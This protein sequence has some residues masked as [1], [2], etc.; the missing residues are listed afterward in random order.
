VTGGVKCPW[1]PF[2]PAFVVMAWSVLIPTMMISSVA[3]A[4]QMPFEL[5]GTWS[6]NC[7]DP[8]AEQIVLES[9]AVSIVFDGGRHAYAGV[10]VSHTWIGGTKAAGDRVWLLT[11][12][13]AGKPYDFIIYRCSDGNKQAL[14]EQPA[15]PPQAMDSS[16]LATRS[17]HQA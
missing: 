1:R 11:S 2:F 7:D 8:A 10:D 16:T 13:A 6:R 5:L 14:D 17:A 4:D 15:D 12:K 9:G 3:L